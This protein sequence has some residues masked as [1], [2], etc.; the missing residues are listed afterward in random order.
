M[1]PS[2]A[3]IVLDVFNFLDKNKSGIVN[4]TLSGEL[5]FKIFDSFGAR[6]ETMQT[7]CDLYGIEFGESEF[8]AKMDEVKSASKLATAVNAASLAKNCESKKLPP[9]DD[10]FKHSY[11]KQTSHS[12]KFPIVSAEV[13]DVVDVDDQGLKAILLDKTCC[14]GESGGQAGD[15]GSIMSSDNI[16]FFNIVD[17]LKDPAT[18]HVWHMGLCEPHRTIEPG[19]RVNVQ[20]KV[21]RRIMLM[22][23]HTGVHLL[24][25]VLHKMFRFTRQQSSSVGIGGFKFDFIALNA[26]VDAEVVN[27]IEEVVNMYID[28]AAPVERIVL[29]N[30]EW[31]FEGSVKE[32]LTNEFDGKSVILMPEE[33]YPKELSVISLPDSVEPCCGTH[34]LNTA[35]V[36]GFVILSV[37]SAHPGQKSFRCLTGQAA[38]E[39]REAGIK[40]IDEVLALNELV[41]K[42]EEDASLLP[43]ISKKI[44]K[45][46]KSINSKLPYT[47]K[48]EVEAILNELIGHIADLKSSQYRAPDYS[49]LLTSEDECIVHNFG[50]SVNLKKVSKNLSSLQKP[51]LILSPSQNDYYKVAVNIPA[52]EVTN[53]FNADRWLSALLSNEHIPLKKQG[54]FLMVKEDVHIP[55]VNK[56]IHSAR[57]FAE[58]ARNK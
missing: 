7:I 13:L 38:L 41:E 48:V 47:V 44:N 46:Q 42:A 50:V 23:G 28:M 36:Q 52:S 26:T 17:T 31:A 8:D 20:F 22:Q 2:D 14:Y 5:A 35:D 57:L 32:M 19:K 25:C 3:K 43:E 11:E 4:N 29:P 24:N 12:Y 30:P 40:L 37:K 33:T 15:E 10:S 55:D 51:C 53:E 16:K 56:A 6:K 1:D 18:G 27:K 58:N 49:D 54:T 39:S 21:S 34:V 9:T 45:F